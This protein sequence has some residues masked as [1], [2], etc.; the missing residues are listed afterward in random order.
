M[1]KEMNP[2]PNE[3]C[4]TIHGNFPSLIPTGI[5][6]AG[7][8]SLTALHIAAVSIDVDEVFC[9]DYVG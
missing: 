4:C 9:I 8:V 6:R 2:G 1:I 5:N 3:R 7:E